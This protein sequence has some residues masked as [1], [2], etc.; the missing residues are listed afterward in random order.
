MNWTELNW[1]GLDWTG[2]DWTELHW[3]GMNWAELNW[4]GLN[5]T[6]L[7]WT[8]L[9]WSELHW[10]ELKWTGRKWNGLNW[11][12]LKWSG[13]DWTELTWPELDFTIIATSHHYNSSLYIVVKARRFWECLSVCLSVIRQKTVRAQ[14]D[15]CSTWWQ[16]A[17]RVTAC[18]RT[19]SFW[20]L[21]SVICV[22]LY[23]FTT[24]ILLK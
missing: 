21:S 1:T 10:S 22:S 3:T 23:H 17:V 9:S 19:F 14:L 8:E 6:G 13:L 16:S 15:Q 7:D 2:L 18:S 24:K 20:C 5:Y 12:G 11:T 4:T